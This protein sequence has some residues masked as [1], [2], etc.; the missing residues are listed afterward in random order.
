MSRIIRAALGSAGA[1]VGT[2]ATV[3]LFGQGEVWFGLY[4][5]LIT[6]VFGLVTFCTLK[7]EG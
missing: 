3:G 5:A 7:E 6:G 2:I 1:L 4:A